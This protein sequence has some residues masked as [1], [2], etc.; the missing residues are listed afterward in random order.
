MSSFEGCAYFRLRTSV[1]SNVL[2][3]IQLSANQGAR[4]KPHTGRCRHADRHATHLAFRC[5]LSLQTAKGRTMRRLFVSALSLLV[6]ALAVA[7]PSEPMIDPVAQR[8]VAIEL[9]ALVNRHYVTTEGAQALS[10]ALQSAL[11]SGLFDQSV[12]ESEWIAQVNQLMQQAVPD[13]HLGVLGKQRYRQL[14]AQF[15]PQQPTPPSADRSAAQPDSAHSSPTPASTAHSSAH[16]SGATTAGGDQGEAL[17]TVAGVSAVAE[18]GRDGLNQVG[19][20]ALQRFDGSDRAI[21][22]ISRIMATFADSDR[23]VIDLRQCRGGDVEM[24]QHLSNFLYT[25]RTH[26]LSNLGPKDAAGKQALTER[27]AEPNSLSAKYASKPVDVLISEHTFS[28]AES[29]AFGLKATGRARLIGE[30]SGG[31]GHMNDFYALPHGFGVSISIGRTFD[32][33]TGLGWESSGVR[34]DVLTQVDHALSHTVGLIT[35][36]SGKLAKLDEHQRDVHA[37]L[38]RYANAWYRGDEEQMAVILAP[39]FHA[40]FRSEGMPLQRNRSA[41]LSATAAGAGEQPRLYHNRI[42]D[43]IKVDG[44]QATARLVLRAT[45]HEMRLERTTQGWRVAHDLGHNK[46][47]H[48]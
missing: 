7:T 40:L 1:R 11:D 38:Q 8:D 47:G 45:S 39:D 19:Y 20:L 14:R 12:S 16:H 15:H 42:I 48:S 6:S 25:K 29:F 21:A 28:A 33:R 22:A 43:Q 9:Q 35:T 13:R 17:L 23:L 30:P 4:I 31:G 34:P 10:T 41:Q 37:V 3:E 32:P 27:W 2:G 24:V 18:I 26:L 5:R 36:E 44:D 46:V